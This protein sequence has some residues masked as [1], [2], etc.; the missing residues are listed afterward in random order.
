MTAPPPLAARDRDLLASLLPGYEIGEV[1]G[2]GACGVVVAG[3]HRRLGREVAL[4]QLAPGFGAGSQVADR[5][6]AEA[7]VLASLDHPH[8]VRLYDFVEGDG[9]GVLVM[10]RL[11]GGTL[12][13]RLVGG[14]LGPA[15]ACAALVATCTG[16]EYAHGHGVLHRDVKP[17][18]LLVSADGVLKV[19]DFGIA[20]LLA[21]SPSAATQTGMV[22]GTPAYIAPEQV[23][24]GTLTPA[25]DVYG[26]GAV[27]YE[28]LSG[29]LPFPIL[30][31][32]LAEL[33]QRITDEPIALLE[34]APS[35][36]PALAAIVDRALCRDPAGRYA[37][38][39]ELGAAIAAVAQGAWPEGWKAQSAIAIRVRLPGASGAFAAP[40]LE[41]ARLAARA[42]ASA[43]AA[44]TQVDGPDG[45]RASAV[46]QEPSDGLLEREQDRTRLRAVAEAAREGT[47]AVVL[48]RGPA[49]IGKSRLIEEAAG[50]CAGTGVKA[51]RARGGEME[52][53]FPYGVV[54]QLLEREV[55]ARGGAALEGAARLAGPA[56]GLGPER[57]ESS[58]GDAEREFT[59][60]HG[61][62]WLL[63]DLAEVQPLGLIV[64]ELQHVDAPSMR[65]LLY[66]ARRIGG[67]RIAIVAAARDGAT[68]ADP[69]TLAQLGSEP[70]VRV[71]RPSGLG[72][73][74]VATLVRA[75][76]AREPSGEFVAG[77]VEVT[78]G[79]PF[80]LERLLEAAADEGLEPSAAA[81]ARIHEL[82]PDA[83]A[84]SVLSRL[85]RESPEL[86]ALARAV[87]VLGDDVELRHAAQLADVEGDVAA[88]CADRLVE[89]ALLRD[90]EPLS[91]LHP[92]LRSTVLAAMRPA[93]RSA[94]HARAAEVL[95]ADG[96]AAAA[97]AAH[98]V[99]LAPAEDASVVAV[100][101]AAAQEALDHGAA[102]I[103]TR[104]L[105][106]AEQEPPPLSQRGVVLA[107]LGHAASVAGDAATAAEA[108][109]ASVALAVEPVE[110]LERRLRA[111]RAHFQLDGRLDPREIM[112][113]IADVDAL[114]DEPEAGTQELVGDVLAAG[115]NLPGLLSELGLRLA[116]FDAAAGET[117]T[118]RVMLAALSR[119]ACHRGDP[120]DRAAGFAERALT[121]GVAPEAAE[122]VSRFTAL[123]TLIDADR[124]DAA[125]EQLDATLVVSRR[126]GSLLGYASVVGCQALAAYQRGD[127]RR[128]VSEAVTALETGALH[129]GLVPVVMACLVRARLASGDVAGAAELLAPLGDSE[130][131]DVIVFNHALVARAQVRFAVGDLEGALEDFRD[132]LERCPRAVGYSRVLPWRQLAVPVLL[133]AGENRQAARVAAEDVAAARRWGTPGGVGGALAGEA[134]CASPGQRLALLRAAIGIL[135]R[136]PAR[137]DLAAAQLGLGETLTALDAPD[138]A[139]GPLRTG[140]E[141]AQACGAHALVERGR[142]A[143]DAAGAQPLQ[144]V[145]GGGDSLTPGQRRVVDLAVQGWSER[146]IAEALFS[147]AKAVEEELEGVYAKLGL[148]GLDDL[149]AS[150]PRG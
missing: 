59:V 17:Q 63:C 66:L 81:V 67:L 10:E 9:H 144:E 18:N 120:A 73:E 123:F 133:A 70:G 130:I 94:A 39:R 33:Q 119:V 34:R 38:A 31:N 45:E 105:Q 82:V 3:V 88:D 106:R 41:P 69:A 124:L 36:P 145:P 101:R 32:A 56:L 5:F 116:R 97:V 134:L 150:R 29:E 96:V 118:E 58:S 19:A 146:E 2:R 71:I 22:L 68:A 52:R 115:T 129:G 83:V 8:V 149:V 47:G 148:R 37:S 25:V 13:T 57:G 104:H 89:L 16:L 92:L 93:G 75:R 43:P 117:A 128:A 121:G 30:G 53:D 26:A 87:A 86:T 84:A 42:D 114:G 79:N 60:C 40:A 98:V 35:V 50:L 113:I 61:L 100:L 27:L 110:R 11:T 74:G 141:L 95:R 46:Q 126:R 138:Q 14:G 99:E 65:F 23:T 78:G 20:K 80:L 142:A 107:E 102:D 51:L 44:A 125:E 24:G 21:G 72:A 109:D 137:L 15:A 131:P 139:L 108:L 48:L 132:A 4:K 147:T 127:V 77:C 55:R 62:F 6:L 140:L 111:F 12:K 91:F 7:R 112:T 76:L 85:E 1:L 64:D 122:A 143:L 49:G 103:A 135:G 28:L 136:S 90:G 54:R